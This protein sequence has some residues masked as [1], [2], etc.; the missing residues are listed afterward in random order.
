LVFLIAAVLTFNFLGD[1]LTTEIEFANNPESQ[2]A[3]DLLEERLRGPRKINE[4]AIVKSPTLTVDDPAF[5]EFVARLYDDITSLGSEIIA[6]GMHYYQFGLA[7][8][9]SADRHTTILPFMMVGPYDEASD[10]ID[11]VHEVISKADGEA[12]FQVLI[13][14][15]ASLGE[16][17]SEVA[18]KDL[19]TGEL[20]GI[21]AALIVLVLVFGALAAAAIP[22]VLAIVAIVVALG[23]TALVGQGFDLS[24]FVIN[25][26]T[27]MGLAFGIDYSLLI[28]SRYREERGRGLNKIDAIGAAGGTASRTVLFSGVVVVLALSGM[29]VV[30]LS[31]FISL[32]TGAILALIGA[33]LAALTLLP[34]LLG[35]IGDKVNALR[36]PLIGRSLA[37]QDVEKRGGFWDWAARG[38][39][40]RPVISLVVAAGLLIAAAIPAFS[41]NTGAAGVTTLPDG[42]QSKEGFLILDE[43]F[44]AGL[45]TPAEIVIDGDIDSEPVQTGIERLQTTL[46]SAPAFDGAFQLEVNPSGDLA[47]LSAPVSGDYTG[48]AAIKAVRTLRGEY[49]PQAFSGVEADVLVTGYT[50]INIDYFDVTDDYLPIVFAFVL[51]L[52]FVL[53][54]MVF[55][56]LV[57]PAKAI[58]MNLLSVG[59]AYGLMVLVF[60]D[61]VGAGLLGFQQVDTIDAWIPIF[62]F[63]VLFGLSMDY[64]VFLLSR[65]RERFDRTHDNRES[66][67]FGIRSTARVITGAAF[68]MVAVFAGFAAGDLVTFQ[69]MGF[70]LGV[71][72]FLDA[73]VVRS[74]L[75]PAAMQLLGARNWYLPRA[76]RWLPRLYVGEGR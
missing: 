28:L 27:G 41:I 47:L 76:L 5:G 19:E 16:D 18:D 12:G 72:V 17:F 62:L 35:L 24:V 34:A 36:V 60:Q 64:H 13:S 61:G 2:R 4:I 48:D 46:E 8:L 69:Q 40:R 9:V 44:S 42:L 67:A 66:V 52:S 63:C 65:I 57:V 74:V 21:P 31:V 7:S 73:T 37:R 53:L 23:A 15:E 38:V 6:G 59:A 1:V 68:I 43:E 49:I 51:G 29:L 33:L 30:P 39:M 25:I 70:G 22:L 56:S 55:R 50:A 20:I 45:V 54:T 75:V 71:A 10:N 26:V 58:I 3:D 32:A 11:Q 14:G